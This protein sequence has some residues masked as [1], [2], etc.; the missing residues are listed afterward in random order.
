MRNPQAFQRVEQL[1]NNNGDPMKLYREITGG[2]NEQQMNG[3]INMAKQFGFSED[4]IKG[5]NSNVDINK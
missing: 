1:K 3:F 5:I 4:Q 2:F